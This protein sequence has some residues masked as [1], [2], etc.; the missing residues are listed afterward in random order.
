MD[1]WKI[2]QTRGN[3]GSLIQCNALINKKPGTIASYGNMSVKL[4]S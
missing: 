1:K 4:A 3:I 2:M